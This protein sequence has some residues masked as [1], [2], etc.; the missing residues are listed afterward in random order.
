MVWLWI[1]FGAL[2]VLAALRQ[3]SR[4]RANRPRRAAPTIDDAAIRQI[5]GK[6][7]LPSRDDDPPLDMKAAAQAEEEFWAESWDEPEEYRS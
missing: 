1:L 6:G 4:L 3:R 5:I 7:R 2:V